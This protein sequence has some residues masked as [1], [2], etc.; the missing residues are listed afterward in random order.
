MLEPNE[1]F[2]PLAH[3]PDADGPS[4]RDVFAMFAMAGLLTQHVSVETE[5]GARNIEPLYF[6]NATD[7]L[8]KR[9]VDTADALIA[10]LNKTS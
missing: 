4:V 3:T 7:R 8:V 2:F 6:G 10:E 5:S 9:A 1:A